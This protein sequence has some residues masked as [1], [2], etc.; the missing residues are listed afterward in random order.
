MT[1]T[2]YEQISG[3]DDVFHD[4]TLTDESTG[5]PLETGTVTM[6]Y[7]FPGTA[8]ALGT[9]SEKVLTHVGSGR[10]TGVHD[11][12]DIATAIAS[13]ASGATFDRCVIVAGTRVKRLAT[14]KKV[15]VAE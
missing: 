11:D 12:A 2:T 7:C 1:T 8:T 6:R 3:L 14:C 10:W 4:I 5:T 13:L 15:V 9:G